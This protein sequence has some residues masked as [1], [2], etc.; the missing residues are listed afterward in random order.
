MSADW[1]GTTGDV[2]WANENDC[3][4]GRYIYSFRPTSGIIDRYDISARAWLP[5]TGVTYLPNFAYA[6][7]G[8]SC[9]DGRYIYLMLPGTASVPMR[10]YKYS[11][12]GNY[13]EPLTEDWFLGG[14]AVKG[15]KMWIKDL[16]SE[17][18]VKWLYYI[19]GTSQIMRRIMLF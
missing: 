11:V 9:W 1:V 4:D 19:S 15:N 8:S 5:T 16:S 10:F 13:V 17:G 18:T 3:L 6:N 2:G 14:A 12:R 7:G